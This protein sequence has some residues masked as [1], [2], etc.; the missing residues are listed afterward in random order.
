MKRIICLLMLASMTMVGRAE[1]KPI[2]VRTN[3]VE[4]RVT[5]LSP[6]IVRV[7][8]GSNLDKE[9]QKSLVVTMQPEANVKL[10]V[11]D[12]SKQVS[13]T[14]SALTVV[15]NKD[16]GQVQFL[17]KGKNL[18]KEK[19][20]ALTPRLAQTYILDK[21]EPIYGLGAMQDGKLNLRGTE[22]RR[23]E[24]SNMED[25]QY[26]IQSLKGWGIFW[27]NYSRANFRDNAEGMTFS[28]ETGEQL[29]YYFMYGQSA[30][31]VNHLMRQLSGQ[32][33]LMPLWTYGYWQCRER[34]KSSRELLEV[35]DW[36]RRNQVPLD[37]IIQDWQYWG[38]NYL[39]NAM[40]FLNEEFADG[41]RM[42]D[43]VHEQ[44]AHLMISIWASFGPMTHQY[45]ELD[46]K[47]LL[48][49]FETWPQSGSGIWP[50]K[51]EEYPSG[52]R[53]Y[54]PYSQE[55]RD[56]YWKHLRKLFDYG[57]DA[58]WMDSTDPDYFGA[59]DEDYNRPI[60]QSPSLG[61]KAQGTWRSH[62]NAF[63]L[64]SVSGVYDNQR[65]AT[66]DK[67]VFVMTRS[68]FA[69]QQR[70]AGGL[71][72]GDVTSSW[73]VLRKQIPLC[74]NYTMTGAPYVNTD[75][76]GFFCGRYGGSN[77]PKNPNYK[78]LYVRWMQFGLFC[79][80]FRSHGADAPREIYQF[81]KKGEPAFDAIEATIRL[82][83]RL[84]PYIYST[85]WDVTNNDGSYM[86][87]LV[88][89]FPNDQ[90]TW[91]MNDE[92][93]FGRS[94]LALP[95]TH[96]QY[97]TEE[98][99]AEGNP[100]FTAAKTIK[101]YLPA[102]ITWYDFWTE[103][104]YAGGQD[105]T[106]PTTLD[107]APMMVRAGAILPL[108]PVMQYAQE[109]QWD[110]LEVIVYPGL[111]G[112]FTLYEDEGDSYRYEQGQYSTVPFKWNDK[113]RE[114]TIAARKG[115]FPGMLAS[116]TFRIRLAGSQSAKTVTYSGKEV[117]VKL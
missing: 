90:R 110:D 47:G 79:P 97:T 83:Y 23:M 62:R 65:K 29:D 34:Y 63:P 52:V 72:S 43:R 78:E 88:Y 114:L 75:I 18:L 27:D 30:D 38:S 22:R 19:Q 81:G 98:T 58:W 74:L 26:V 44:K 93:L 8:H 25:F 35:V 51:R 33:P 40:D 12:A 60:G 86:R 42:I 49:D 48:F 103:K 109:S 111:D 112:S 9:S 32:A 82:R 37:G 17:A 94:I 13:L 56:I 46:E 24:Q 85:A 21:D 57:V 41:R 117:K 53:V 100:D 77:A 31:G 28:P 66:N 91:D 101:R 95:V 10:S 96:P 99:R 71:W 15:I 116:R 5:F 80:V 108:A 2:E 73:D 20:T 14:S 3:G 1:T 16:D 76:G 61:I 106:L 36:H 92:F 54:D 39:W 69:G 64:A 84:M 6:A 67:R 7:Q 50:P 115:Q 55:A 113:K 107:H 68:A 59:K 11:K 102:G 104:S 105:I 87:A 89:D 4:T 70:Y 45:K